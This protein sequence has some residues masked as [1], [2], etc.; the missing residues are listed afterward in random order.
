MSQENVHSTLSNDE[1]GENHSEGDPG[2]SSMQQSSTPSEL[3]DALNLVFGKQT[4]SRAVHA[5]GIV[6]EGRFLPQSLGGDLEQGTALSEGRSSYDRPIFR[7]CRHT[8]GFRHQR[9]CKPTRPGIEVPPAR[10]VGNG[11]R[12][13]FF[14]WFP[15]RHR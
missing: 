1:A 14:Q 6:L 3:V 10:W 2:T 8:Y 11:S 9:S 12:D 7:F 15:R 4:F 13:A 5:K